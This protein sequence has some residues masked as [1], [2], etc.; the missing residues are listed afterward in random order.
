MAPNREAG[1]PVHP[2]IDIRYTCKMTAPSAPELTIVILCRNEEM[3]I[4]HCVG[5]ARR[6]LDRHS[7]DGEVVVVDN[8]SHDQSAARARDAGARV[9]EEISPGYGNAINAG[10]KAARGHLIILG[11]GDGEHDLGLL[12]PYYEKLH[13]GYDFVF[14]NR[15]SEGRDNASSLL[16][17]A[18]TTVLSG[19]GKRLFH[20]PVSDFNCGLRGFKAS[21][22][23]SLALRCSGMEAASEMIVK[24][25]RADMRIAEVPVVQRNALDPDR[26]SHVRIVQDGWRHLRLLLMLSPRWLYFYPGC[27]LF[28][29]GVLAMLVPIL[30]P[31]EE[32]GRF[33]SYTMLFGS[34]FVV[35]G[36]QLAL[37]SLLASAFCE[38]IGLSAGLW[39]ARLKSS[40]VLEA[41]LTTGFVMTL[42]GAVGSIWSLFIWAQTVGPDIDTRI[43][44]AIPSLTLSICGVH[45]IFSAFFLALLATQVPMSGAARDGRDGR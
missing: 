12:E 29:A 33:G 17:N 31:V 32:G 15:F 9:V 19:V 37:F 39:M 38:S 22:A 18:G 34:A 7:I 21:S 20:T 23:R 5:E 2:L 1:F 13:E 42:L 40:L 27:A 30:H 3:S 28:V 4:V 44:V 14:G 16:R 41:A 6:F 26:V 36:V 45:L 11:D 43:R 35:C 10:I 24:A 8:H 25:A